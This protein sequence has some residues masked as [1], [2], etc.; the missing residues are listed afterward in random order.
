IPTVGAWNL[1]MALAAYVVFAVL[2]SKLRAVLGDLE[3]RVRERTKALRREIAER[4]RLDREIAEVADRERRRLGQDLHDSLCQHLTGTAL[5]AQVLK[6]KLATKSVPEASEAEKL[7]RY[8]EEGN[9]L[10][11]HLAR[12]L[13]SSDLETT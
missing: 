8:V 10:N 12:G 5:A 11:R 13:Y 1:V 2:L 7:V 9:D 4:Q 6:D 3:N